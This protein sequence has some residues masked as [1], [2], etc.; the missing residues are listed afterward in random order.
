MNDYAIERILTVSI[1]HLTEDD[2][3][4]L[5]EVC[6]GEHADDF[7]TPMVFPKGDYGWFVYCDS[8][9]PILR[10]KYPALC[11]AASLASKNNCCWVAFDVDGLTVD[12]LEEY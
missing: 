6:D 8:V 10:D 3:K 1:S 7:E 4:Y 11:K 12:E 9:F 2:C 5:D